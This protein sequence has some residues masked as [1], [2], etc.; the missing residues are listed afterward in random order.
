MAG[1]GFELKKLF[2]GKGYIR[3]IRAYLYTA[4]I[5]VGPTILCMTMVTL[6][7]LFLMVTG[8]GLKER[9]LFLAAVTYSFI[10]SLIIT[11]GFS[12]IVTRYI[13]D[14]I[15]D[16][17][18]DDIL[19]SLYGVITI[20][21]SLGGILGI[22][23]YY[24]SPLSIYFRFVAY[25]LYMELIIVWLI[26]VYLSA[27]RDY[28][29]IVKSF[30]YGIIVT[31]ACAYVFLK[32]LSIE[33][34]FGCILAMDIGVFLIVLLLLLEIKKYFVS[35]RKGY[36]RFLIYL[37]KYPALFLTGLFY[38]TGLYVHNFVFWNSSFSVTAGDTYV[39]CPYY[40][41]PSFYAMLTII[42]AMVIFVATVETSFYEKYKDYYS[43]VLGAGTLED[44]T[45]SKEEMRKVLVHE[46][47]YTMELQLF[48]SIIFMVIGMRLLPRIGLIGAAVD[49]FNILVLGSYS[50]VIMFIIML[51]LLYFDDRRGAV[52]V[53]AMFLVTNTLFTIGTL[54]LGENFY[55]FGFFA[56]A[57]IT[58]IAAIIRLWIFLRNIDYYTFCSQPVVFKEKERF[59]QR[60]VSRFERLME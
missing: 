13:S 40:D 52:F 34:A 43:A 41:V 3:N 54:Y 38:T 21:I 19:P 45:R 18:Y 33:S 6:L 46:I 31:L 10:F 30:L 44:I 37:D 24:I 50:C 2:G 15:F 39:F 7:Q 53:S 51:V 56:A 29:R 14:K 1:I 20:C 55:G 60:L 9:E 23:F 35:N 27:L 8:V 42:T 4:L 5:T 49:I 47:T 22:A 12:M 11:S 48:F 58:L 26:S 36:F 17:S 57:F 16:K 25:T 32:F 59:F 28:M